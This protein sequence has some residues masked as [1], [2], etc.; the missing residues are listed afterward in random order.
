MVVTYHEILGKQK[1]EDLEAQISNYWGGH[2]RWFL[3]ALKDD[4]QNYCRREQEEAERRHKELVEL[5]KKRLA[6]E[7]QKAEYKS[8]WRNKKGNYD[9]IQASHQQM[10][11]FI[12]LFDQKI[13][14]IDEVQVRLDAANQLLESDLMTKQ[15]NVLVLCNRL[16]N[17]EESLDILRAD[18]EELL[19][20]I[21]V[22]LSDIRT[23]A[24]TKLM[25][26]I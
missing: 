5:E 17:L 14:A 24:K 22:E 6:L 11:A 1:I 9:L 10:M 2:Y 20:Q 7:K 26:L 8:S 16:K 4:Y 21:W 25:E 3:G 18:N 15:E 13:T 12:S 23:R 19:S